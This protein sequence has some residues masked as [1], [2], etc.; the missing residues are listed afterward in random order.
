VHRLLELTHVA[1]AAERS[2]GEEATSEL[3]ALGLTPREQ[4]VAR[5]ALAGRGNAAIARQLRISESTVK[6]HMT[7]V[8]AK[9]GVRSRTQLIALLSDGPSGD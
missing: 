8:L 7:R 5:L 6:K 4:A 3:A 1:R 9:A 2:E